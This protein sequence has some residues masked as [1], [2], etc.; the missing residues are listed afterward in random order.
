MKEN[1]F[2][3][4]Q[5]REGPESEACVCVCVC[6]VEGVKKCTLKNSHNICVRLTLF[7][8][9]RIFK[10]TTSVLCSHRSQLQEKNITEDNFL[11]VCVSGCEK[12]VYVWGYK[13]NKHQGQRSWSLSKQ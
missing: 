10:P 9:T 3:R 6:V 8:C 13:E 11:T 2:D 7:S 4:S 5:R 12:H 1:Q